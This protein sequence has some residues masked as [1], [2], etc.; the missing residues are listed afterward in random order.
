MGTE[1]KHKT[2]LI[3]RHGEKPDNKNDPKLSPAGEYRASQLPK[4]FQTH[5]P[6]IKDYVFAAKKSKHSERPILTI[7]P[8]ADSYKLNLN[9]HLD[10]EDYS[11]LANLLSDEKFKQAGIIIC[12]HHSE[13]PNL[14]LSLGVNEESLP[15]KK[16]PSTVFDEVW[17]IN[18]LPSH[19][20]VEVIKENIVIP[21]IM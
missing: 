13:I 7:Q 2:I 16:W 15:Y 1:L 8:T 9:H 21:G 18:Y 6:L 19:V 20:N 4:F 12:W 5:F 11:K 17:K 10:V 3:L 14:A